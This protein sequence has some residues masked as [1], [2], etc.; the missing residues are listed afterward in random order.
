[1]TGAEA[2]V[3]SQHLTLGMRL[4]QGS[5]TG[6]QRGDSNPHQRR[7]PGRP[8]PWPSALLLCTKICERP[9]T[10]IWLPSQQLGGKEGDSPAQRRRD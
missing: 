5:S 3:T 9:A 10:A 4:Q 2:T 8:L 1:M 6:P 7:G